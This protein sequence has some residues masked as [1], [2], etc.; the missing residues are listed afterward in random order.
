[1]IMDAIKGELVKMDTVTIPRIEYNAMVR[2]IT[3]LTILEDTIME[4]STLSYNLKELRFDDDAID[5]ILKVIVPE[6]YKDRIETLNYRKE[7][8]HMD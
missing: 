5:H 8:E 1:M 3:K 6:W 4:S 7:P 2:N